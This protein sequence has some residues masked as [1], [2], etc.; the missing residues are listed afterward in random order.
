MKAWFVRFVSLYVFNVAVL[1]IV[2]W[3]MPAV[4]VGFAALWAGLILTAATIW[5]KPLIRKAFTGMAAKSANERTKF[6]ETLVQ[7]GLVFIV[8]LIVWIAVVLF[9]GVHVRGFFWGWV[10]PPIAL[11]IAWAIYAAIDDRVEAKTS[12]IFGMATD[13]RSESVDAA[14]TSAP[15]SP[16]ADAGRRELRDGL[17]DEQRKLFDEL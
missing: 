17:T 15:P 14:G 8:E 4:R 9:S 1:L 12:A 7:W 5:L 2:G 16:A 3:I 10:L 6:G 11:L 13:G